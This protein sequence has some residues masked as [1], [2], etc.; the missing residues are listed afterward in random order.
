MPK[1]H[2]RAELAHIGRVIYKMDELSR[3][4]LIS[5]ST[6]LSFEELSGSEQERVPKVA[7]I[8]RRIF[9]KMLDEVIP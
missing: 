6:R 7:D 9:E 4:N 8:V 5:Y 1:K 2:S 3:L